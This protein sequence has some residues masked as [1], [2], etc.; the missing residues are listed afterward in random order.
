MDSGQLPRECATA[1]QHGGGLWGQWWRRAVHLPHFPAGGPRAPFVFVRKGVHLILLVAWLLPAARSTGG[2]SDR[3]AVRGKSIVLLPW[4]V[5]PDCHLSDLS[6][7]MPSFLSSEPRGSPKR[8]CMAVILIP[9][10]ARSVFLQT[11]LVTLAHELPNIHSTLF[12]DK[13]S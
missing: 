13:S 10:L 4:L 12:E 11:A 7:I 1:V 2:I 6:C 3:V 5:C 8:T 9:S